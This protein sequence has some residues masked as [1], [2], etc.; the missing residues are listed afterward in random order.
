MLRDILRPWLTWPLHSPRRFFTVLVIV[1]L[2]LTV[3]RRAGETGSD[4]APA[5]SAATAATTATAAS[6]PATQPSPAA[7]AAAGT[8]TTTT[9]S[10]RRPRPAATPTSAQDVVDAETGTTAPTSS[11]TPTPRPT[12]THN[13]AVHDAGPQDEAKAAAHAFVTAWARPQAKQPA[14]SKA[15]APYTDPAYLTQLAKTNPERVPATKVTGAPQLVTGSA[16]AAQFAVPTDAGKMSVLV[17]FDG[18]AWLVAS[19]SPGD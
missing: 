16:Y 18:T 1:V 5:A 8:P 12:E 10:S 6:S 19:I 14:W 15:L 3:V 13:D 9:P 7:T 2:A 4:T 17:M 11:A